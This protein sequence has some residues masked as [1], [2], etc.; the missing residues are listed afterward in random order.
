MD[1]EKAFFRLIHI[2]DEEISTKKAAVEA[3]GSE[4]KRPRR[5]KKKAVEA[6]GGEK[7]APS[8]ARPAAVEAPRELK[9]RPHRGG[10]AVEAPT[11]TKAISTG[12]QAAVE[13][14]TLR[15]RPSLLLSLAARSAGDKKIQ[16]RRK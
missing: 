7:N 16:E 10:P 6:P 4:K 2:E 9:K 3:P 15:R 1:S 8:G 14:S 11:M 5:G 13:A 12:G